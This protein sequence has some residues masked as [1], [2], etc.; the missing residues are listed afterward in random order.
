M[1]QG[2]KHYNIIFISF[3]G[4]ER[5]KD[6]QQPVDNIINQGGEVEATLAQLQGYLIN[7]LDENL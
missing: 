2:K 1:N 7:R 4:H 3:V 6:N 5:L